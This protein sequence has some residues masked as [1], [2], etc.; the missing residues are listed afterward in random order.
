MARHPARKRKRSVNIAAL[1]AIQGD[2]G[3]G[4]GGTRCLK[5]NMVMITVGCQF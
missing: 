1:L 2:H 5:M 3:L 4:L